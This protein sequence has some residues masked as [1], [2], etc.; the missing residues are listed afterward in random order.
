MAALEETGQLQLVS[1]SP[2]TSE[3]HCHSTMVEADSSLPGSNLLSG[4][5]GSVTSSGR[6]GGRN[7]WTW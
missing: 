2:R 3:S 5:T 6:L 4:F 1:L 7:S